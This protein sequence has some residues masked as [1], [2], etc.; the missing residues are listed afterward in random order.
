ML[1]DQVYYIEADEDTHETG[2][3][4]VMHQ[5][6]LEYIAD[7]GRPV[8]FAD[9]EKFSIAAMQRREGSAE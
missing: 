7:Q 8:T 9:G 2:E 4:K 5:T 1:H 3:A 6:V